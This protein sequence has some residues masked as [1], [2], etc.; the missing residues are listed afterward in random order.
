V[1]VWRRGIFLWG[2]FVNAPKLPNVDCPAAP[3]SAVVIIRMSTGG[4]LGMCH[5]SKLHTG[6][7][8]HVTYWAFPASVLQATNA[9]VRRPGYEV[10]VEA[11]WR[12]MVL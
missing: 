12:Q 4:F 11:S 10:K 8:L 9:G 5:S 2:G 1:D 7:S 6:T 3:W